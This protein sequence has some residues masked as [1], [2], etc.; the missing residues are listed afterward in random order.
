MD[1]QG[2]KRR[3]VMVGKQDGNRRRVVVERPGDGE[4]GQGGV[5]LTH[6]SRVRES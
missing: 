2:K 5:T 6:S 3:K 1:R 4:E